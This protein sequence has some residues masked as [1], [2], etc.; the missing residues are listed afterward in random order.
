MTETSSQ[1][2]LIEDNR[3]DAGLIQEMLRDTHGASLACDWAGSL[4]EGLERLAQGGID[5]VLLDLELPDSHGLETLRRVQEHAPDVPVVVLTGLDDARTALEALRAGAEDLLVRDGANSCLLGRALRYAAQRAQARDMLRE[6]NRQLSVLNRLGMALAQTLDLPAIYRL[7]YEHLRELVDCACFGISRF[8]S[9]TRVLRAEFMLA[10]GQPL[11]VA[12]F[13]PL[14]IAEDVPSG[15]GKALNT[16]QPELMRSLAQAVRAN[17]HSV[18]VGAPGDERTAQSAVYVPMLVQGKPVGLLELQSYRED[19]YGEDELALLGP[20]ANQIGLAIQNAVLFQQERQHALALEQH[21]AELDRARQSLQAT[22][23][24]WQATF[25]AMN[26]AI[27]LLD[28]DGNIMRCN[29]A[30]QHLTGL[31][32]GEI[33]GQQVCRLFCSLSEPRPDCPRLRML[34]SMRR[35]TL[36]IPLGE[37]WYQVTL[38]P[39]PGEDGQ[40]AG[41]VHVVSDVTARRRAEQEREELEAQLRQAHKMEAV[42]LLAGGVAHDFNNLLTVILG[43][44]Q[45]GLA[46][47]QP[48]EPPYEELANIERTSQRA[49]ALTQQLLAFGRRR[50]LQPEALDVNHLVGEL[51]KMLERVIG[52]HIELRMDLAPDLPAVQGD[53]GALEQVLMNLVLNARDALPEGGCITIATAPVTLDTAFCNTHPE[54]TPGTYVR[55]SVTDTGTGMSEST[56]QHLFEPF[57]TTKERGK[58]TGLGLAVVHGIVKQHKGLIEVS[59]QLGQGTRVEI[60]LPAQ[61]GAARPAPPPG[62]QGA[63]GGSETILVAEDEELLRALTTTLL[64]GLGYTVLAC[65]D[66][67]E[68]VQLFEGN[69]ERVALLILDMVMP[70]MSGLKAYEA[71][72]AQ[73]PNVPVLF[74]TGYSAEWGESPFLPQAGMHLLQKPFAVG[75]LARKVREALDEGRKSET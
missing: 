24:E 70:R 40:L 51:R 60:C 30:A 65:S 71:I 12:A 44:A 29:R 43:N 58:G 26:D 42:G 13:P 45:L 15:R 39:L 8:D 67:K 72:S 48:N 55:L 32:P 14:T 73:H 18:Q 57:F 6:R 27:T 31:P 10:D 33:V 50:L 64:Q 37:S 23:R 20:V 54:A 11:D 56:R 38:D 3:G 9:A 36:T 17:G 61:R 69:A 34:Q 35:E 75:D 7:A 47:V 1:L 49:A 62:P 63:P 19:A 16:G 46:Q 74:V 2:L 66:G 52:E 28:R 5:L 25:D 4:S 59:S 22:T 53:A 68:A 21:V 41:A